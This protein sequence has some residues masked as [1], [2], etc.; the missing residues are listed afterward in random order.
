MDN[1]K[2]TAI[3][4]EDV[5]AHKKLDI[6]KG[7]KLDYNGNCIPNNKPSTKPKQ[8]TWH[9]MFETQEL[10]DKWVSL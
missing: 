9:L 8:Y 5:A 6:N 10:R 1:A 4:Q 3:T 2:A 7:L